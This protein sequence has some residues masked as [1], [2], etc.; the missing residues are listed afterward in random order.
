V[1]SVCSGNIEKKRGTL[2][3][4]TRRIT[5]ETRRKFLHRKSPSK[6]KTLNAWSANLCEKEKKGLARGLLPQRG[7]VRFE[8]E[9]T[10]HRVEHRKIPA[11]FIA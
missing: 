8:R 9:K 3:K 7:M 11:Y 1:G 10:L 4:A 5:Q 6:E 2:E